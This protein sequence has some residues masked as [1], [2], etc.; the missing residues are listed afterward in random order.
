MALANDKFDLAMVRSKHA[1]PRDNIWAA[2][3]HLDS[4]HERLAITNGARL[5]VAPATPV[6]NTHT[7]RGNL[8]FFRAVD[9]GIPHFNFK[10]IR[11]T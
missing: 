10:I 9:A 8:R 4:Q 7:R 3:F 2:N 5:Y 6:T 1:E 11:I